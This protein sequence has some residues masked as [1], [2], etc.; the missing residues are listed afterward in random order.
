LSWQDHRRTREIC[1]R[2]RID[3]HTLVT[4]S[5]G[6]RRYMT[7]IP[8]TIVLLYRHRSSVVMVQNPSLVL[9]LLA[10]LL[11]RMLSL[12]VVVDA[13]NEAV[14]PYL[15][16]GA[17]VGWITRWLQRHADRVIVTNRHLARI[18]AANGGRPVVL[19]D[20]IP[21]P[22]DTVVPVQVRGPFNVVFVSTFAKDEPFDALLAAAAELGDSFRFYVTGNLRHVSSTVRLTAPPNVMFTGFL[23]DAQYWSLLRSADVIVDLTMI[24]NCLVCG[25]YEGL[26]VGKP[27]VLSSN[28]ASRELFGS[29]ACYTH[30]SSESIADAIRRARADITTVRAEALATRARLER[31]WESDVRRLR[32]SLEDLRRAH[33]H[34]QRKVRRTSEILRPDRQTSHV[35]R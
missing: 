31:V 1:S 7:L 33:P 30:N 35:G 5:R 3:L 14:V 8:K 32:S 2:L 9:T 34:R 17:L 15:N 19:A 27:L 11:R 4:A 29:A 26:A 20:P 13:H 25:A 10:I 16:P 24:D 23:D 22:P 28:E 6:L 18:V 12:R 21:T